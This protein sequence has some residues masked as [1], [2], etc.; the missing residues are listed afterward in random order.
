M[1]INTTLAA[2]KTYFS[3]MK[4]ITSL[5]KLCG[6]LFSFVLVSSCQGDLVLDPSITTN[7]VQEAKL[8][9][10]VRVK[11]TKNAP[12][13]LWEY[14]KEYGEYVEVPM[15]ING[16]FDIPAIEGSINLG[17]KSFLYKTQG[18]VTKGTIVELVPD[19]TYTSNVH[20]LQFSELK[21]V[22]FN[23]L[24]LFKNILDVPLRGYVLNDGQVVKKLKPVKPVEG[25]AIFKEEVRCSV[26]IIRFNCL[27]NGSGGVIYYDHC[28]ELHLPFCWTEDISDDPVGNGDINPCD[29]HEIP[30]LCSTYPYPIP[31]LEDCG[32]IP[33]PSGQ[34]SGGV[35]R[36]LINGP[37][38][39]PCLLSI[40]S[41]MQTF[42]PEINALLQRF[43]NGIP[44]YQ[45]LIIQGGNLGAY[46]DYGT[47]GVDGTTD[48]SGNDLIITINT[49]NISSPEFMTATLL[50]EIFH[51]H[52]GAYWGQPWNNQAQHVC[53]VE[54]KL[55]ERMTVWLKQMYPYLTDSEIKALVWRGFD[56][57]PS[58]STVFPT[59]STD[60]ATLQSQLA[61]KVQ[62]YQN[63]NRD[64][65]NGTRG[66][67]CP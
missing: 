12:V 65:L 60:P 52:L 6:I 64:F 9:Y 50:H 62:F 41:N 42:L 39:S 10:E 16:K 45:S 61:Y 58:F 3:F 14:A 28:D 31:S 51:A 49:D 32:Y 35:I 53:M 37:N 38:P 27:R 2:P 7:K 44:G 11:P 13:P 36:N 47:G 5:L 15:G 24:A 59:N 22:K 66:S 55:A 21:N 57:T 46:D 25:L 17:K 54:E 8:W 1:T 63:L 29:C 18:Q 34:T 26:R 4:Y 20:D 43:R 23:G 56:D 33:P 19:R 67:M 48:P 30:D 40:Q